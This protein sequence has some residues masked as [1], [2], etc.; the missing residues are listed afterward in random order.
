MT[1]EEH[2]V[3]DQSYSTYVN[4]KKRSEKNDDDETPDETPFKIE[5][6]RRNSIGMS[7]FSDF[8]MSS[9]DYGNNRR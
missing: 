4:L 5:E 1:G 8:G 2:K 9:Y 7:Q 6:I 3:D